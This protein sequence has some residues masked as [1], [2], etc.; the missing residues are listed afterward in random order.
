MIADNEGISPY[1]EGCKKEEEMNAWICHKEHLA[2]MMF[3]NNDDDKEDR[4]FSPIY[5]SVNGT[6][7]GNKLNSMMDHMWD[8]FYT[9]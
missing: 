2:V 7:M 8:G 6:K 3:E 4:T 9:G 1:L 5:L